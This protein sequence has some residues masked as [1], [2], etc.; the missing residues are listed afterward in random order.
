[1]P[2]MM[3]RFCLYGFLKNQRYFEPFLFLAFLEKGLGFTQIGLLIAVREVTT[4]LLEIPSGAIA[5]VFGRRLSMIA[6]FVAYIA[7]F[8]LFGFADAMPLLVGGMLL[9]GVGEAFRSGTHKALI[10]AWLRRQGR[11]HERVKVYGHTRSWS[12][13]GSAASVLLAAPIV[14]LSRSYE[15]IFFAAI[16]PYALNVINFLGYPKELDESNGQERS[17]REVLR[18]TLRAVSESVKKPKL[19]RLFAES[20]GFDGVFAAVKDYLQPVLEALALGLT[21]AWVSTGID[22]AS[23]ASPGAAGAP[24]SAPAFFSWTDPAS[25]SDVQRGALLVGPVYFA[26]HMLSGVASRR[27]H[28][29]SDAAGGEERASRWLWC[30]NI[31]VFAALTLGGVANWMVLMAMA[32]VALHVLENVWRPVLISRFDVHGSK[33]QGASLMSIESQA[34]RVATMVVAPVLGWAVDAVAGG[35]VIGSETGHAQSVVGE[36]APVPTWGTASPLWPV[37]AV[38]LASAVCFWFGTRRVS[39]PSSA[40]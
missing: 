24:S 7:A 39:R 5:D 35:G 40:V 32:F 8:V 36:A 6:S 22:G 27:S 37:G 20:M 2:S 29:V 1:M 11:E 3:L 33:A 34:R 31:A 26:L 19:R 17:V 18:H 9:Y 38:G 14:I 15:W 4:G 25:W 13:F 23:S 21:A 10:F 30:V 28:Q 16:P 12:K